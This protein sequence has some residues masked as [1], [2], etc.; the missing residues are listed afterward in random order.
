[1]LDYDQADQ[2]TGLRDVTP[3]TPPVL[4]QT[5][6]YN[7]DASGN[8]L[9][10]QCEPA[11]QSVQNDSGSFNNLNQLTGLN[12]GTSKLNVQGYLDKTGTVTVN[13]QNAAVDSQNRFQAWVDSQPG[14]NTISVQALDT[15][16]PPRFSRKSWQVQ[17]TAGATRTPAYDD[18]GNMTDNGVGQAYQWDAANR[19]IK[20]SYGGTS[21][22]SSQFFYDGL[23]RRVQIVEKDSSGTVTSTKNFV[24][25]N[26]SQPAEERDASNNVTKRF[27]SQGEQ[28]AGTNYYYTLDHL[29]SVREM[30]DSNGVIHARYDYDPYGRATKLSGDL[31][32]DFQY[33]GYYRHA[34]SGL[35]LTLYR[36]Y[37]ADLGRWL[38]RDPI[39][40]EGGI[41]LYAYVANDPFRY[42]DPFG[43]APGDWW[44]IRTP[45]YNEN[46]AMEYAESMRGKGGNDSD[47]HAIAVR[48]FAHNME[49]S[50]GKAVGWLSAILG[51]SGGNWAEI[52]SP[53]SDYQEDM[54]AN[55]YGIGLY[56]AGNVKFPFETP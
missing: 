37:N 55:I 56:G 48:E 18:N 39:E 25:T 19:L 36:A 50:Y 6:S 51:A 12:G 10:A 33:A 34:A 23:G 4:N 1:M 43:L 24:W 45:F 14:T 11:G 3:G 46:R 38:S 20:I 35:N 30:T 15:Q 44:D 2:L 54:E 41:N 53:S 7:Y 16:T 27:Y 17:V 21:A 29:G 5:F 49:C 13:G 32:A 28:I 47:H 31:D 8:R 26:G 52:F 42:R 40:E 22:V 9:A